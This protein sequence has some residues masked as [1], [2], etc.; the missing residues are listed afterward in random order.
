MNNFAREAMQV[1][2]PYLSTPPDPSSGSPQV[3]VVKDQ[4]EILNNFDRYAY[5]RTRSNTFTKGSP[6]G[7]DQEV[8]ANDL[9]QNLGIYVEQTHS[10]AMGFFMDEA[11]EEAAN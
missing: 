3:I 7:S 11:E 1:I 10:E 2:H 6:K 4:A 5:D 8:L 9:N